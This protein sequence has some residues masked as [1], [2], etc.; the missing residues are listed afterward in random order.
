MTTLAQGP[1]QPSPLPTIGEGGAGGV[2]G[3]T[4]TLGYVKLIAH[5]AIGVGQVRRDGRGAQQLYI[6]ARIS[7]D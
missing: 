5:K 7:A 1:R 2:G 4:N 6:T 3:G